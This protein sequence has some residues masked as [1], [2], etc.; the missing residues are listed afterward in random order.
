MT[1]EREL[2][3]GEKGTGKDPSLL[4]QNASSDHSV[5]KKAKTQKLNVTTCKEKQGCE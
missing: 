3:K 4:R 5:R 1:K 2:H